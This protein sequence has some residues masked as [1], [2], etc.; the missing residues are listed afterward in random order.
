MSSEGLKHSKSV[1]LFHCTEELL[2]TLKRWGRIEMTKEHRDK[3]K[4]K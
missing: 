4:R 1:F 3:R 2:V